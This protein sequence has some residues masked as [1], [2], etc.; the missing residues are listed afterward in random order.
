[1]SHGRRNR[2][3]LAAR[4]PASAV[5]GGGWRFCWGTISIAAAAPA[6]GVTINLSGSPSNT[7]GVPGTVTIPAGQTSN[8]FTATTNGVT[9]NTAVSLEASL[10]GVNLNQTSTV[11]PASLASVTLNPT[12]TSPGS[13]VSGTV[14]LNG[15]AGGSTGGAGLNVQLTCSILPM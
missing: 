5:H 15:L 11:V 10:L 9:Q 13:T 6:G 8:S 2:G 3:S 1:M 14:N 7:V 4:L 12:H